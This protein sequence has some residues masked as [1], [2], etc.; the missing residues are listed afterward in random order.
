MSAWQKHSLKPGE[1]DASTTAITGRLASRQHASV[2]GHRGTVR[3]GAV[4]AQ[5]AASPSVGTDGANVTGSYGSA[6][7]AK[8]NEAFNQA[9]KG[10]RATHKPGQLV[11]SGIK[12]S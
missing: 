12:M 1:H 7:N 9:S 2:P 5:H 10:P 8:A 3:K 4:V 11:G 6:P